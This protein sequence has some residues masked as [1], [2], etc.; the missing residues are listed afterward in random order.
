[1]ASSLKSP[2]E[3]RT[4]L[5]CRIDSRRVNRRGGTGY[6]GGSP[7]RRSASKRLKSDIARKFNR[8][9]SKDTT[10]RRHRL[11]AESGGS[12]DS[13]ES[14]LSSPPCEELSVTFSISRV[15]PTHLSHYP[16]FRG[17]TEHCRRASLGPVPCGD[18][19][20]RGPCVCQAISRGEADQPAPRHRA[21]KGAMRRSW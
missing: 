8:F 1:M 7:A 15:R 5:L 17:T 10:E 20:P 19:Q 3:K 6:T 12:G 21:R 16:T 2:R 18:R 4:R 14:V 9:L 11:H 13:G